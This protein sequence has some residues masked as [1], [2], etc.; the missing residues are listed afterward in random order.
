MPVYEVFIDGKPRKI[1]L[2]KNGENTFIVKMDGKPLKVEL[3]TEKLELEEG[4]SIK[5]DD[6]TY[7]VNMPEL[8]RE[9]FFSVKVEEAVF[10]AEIKTTIKKPALAVETAPITPIKKTVELK[11]AMEGAVTAPM[12]GKI[13]SI[14]VKKREQVKAGQVLCILEAMKMENEIAA[15]K[16][17]T[18]QEILVSEG[19]SVS[20]GETLFIIT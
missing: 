20:E 3:S 18:V 19:S 9:E 16:S 11:P 13:L 12:T 14:K 10:K 15:P 5:I 6:R 17:G 1:E 7:Q 8:K 4:F 2:T